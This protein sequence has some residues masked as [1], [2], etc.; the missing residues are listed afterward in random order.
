MSLHMAMIIITADLTFF[1]VVFNC[2]NWVLRWKQMGRTRVTLN[3]VTNISH[4]HWLTRLIPGGCFTNDS[5]A[6]Q[7]NLAKIYNARNYIC[8][9]NSKLKRCTCVQS[10]AWGTRTKFQLEI[11]IRSAISAIHKFR[12]NILESSPNVSETTPWIVLKIGANLMVSV[13]SHVCGSRCREIISCARK[14]LM[15]SHAL[16]HWSLDRLRFGGW[17][18]RI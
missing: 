16:K 3:V 18:I 4:A 12:E 8:Y 10:M 9:E 1:S 5:R 6:P 15:M 7:N 14:A 11:L 17:K 2:K 13:F